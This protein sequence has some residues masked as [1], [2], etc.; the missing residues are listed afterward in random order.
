MAAGGPAP[1]TK[2]L[3]VTIGA[4]WRGAHPGLP[5]SRYWL[6][7]NPTPG[8]NIGIEV[9]IMSTRTAIETHTIV[10]QTVL[11]QQHCAFN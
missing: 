6:R 3:W 8:A 1:V 5:L 10:P 9:E 11:R 4:M 2:W 7:V